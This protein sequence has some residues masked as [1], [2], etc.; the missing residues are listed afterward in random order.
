MYR[1]AKHTGVIM[2]K[3]ALLYIFVITMALVFNC[4]TESVKYDLPSVQATD[5]PEWIG[6]HKAARDTIFIVIHL[7]KEGSIDMSDAVQ[8]AQSELH[9]I[10]INEIEI[11]LHDYWDQKQVMQSEAEQFQLLSGLP[12][13][14]ELMMSHVAISDGWESADEVSILCALDYEEVAKILMLAVGIDDRSFLSHFKRSM[15][16]LAEKYR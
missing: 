1:P 5:K 3:Y 2:R 7:P 6:T 9:K 12:M 10:L 11:T 13:T 4:T 15:D 8:T 14:L 16:G